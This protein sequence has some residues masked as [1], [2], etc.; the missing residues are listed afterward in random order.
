[1]K[2]HGFPLVILALFPLAVLVAQ[3]TPPSPTVGPS[4]ALLWDHSG[5]T[6]TGDPEDLKDADL[7]FTSVLVADLNVGGTITKQYLVPAQKGTNTVL[8]S[9]LAGISEGGMR[10]WVRVRDTAGNVSKWGGPVQFFFDSAPPATP[11]NL[12]VQATAPAP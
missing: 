3:T 2:K 7:A 9:S 1:M 10:A 12:R 4:G 8:L 11:A 6:S 5:L